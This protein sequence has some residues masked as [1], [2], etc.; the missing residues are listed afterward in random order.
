MAVVSAWMNKLSVRREREL[1]QFGFRQ[2][3]A[4]CT[5]TAKENITCHNLNQSKNAE[6]TLSE[7]QHEYICM[8]IYICI[9]I[10]VVVGT[11]VS[12]YIYIYIYIERE[13][14]SGLQQLDDLVSDRGMHLYVIVLCSDCT[15]QEKRTLHAINQSKNLG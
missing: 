8:Y 5:T 1:Q 15:G 12:V 7:I 14:I 2:R 6:N 10:Y 4:F 9:Y 11:C 3:Y 13:S